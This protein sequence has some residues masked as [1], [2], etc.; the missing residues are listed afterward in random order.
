MSTPTQRYWIA[1]NG[2]SCAMSAMAMRDPVVTPTPEQMWGFPT[3]EEAQKAQQICLT[4]PMADVIAFLEGLRQDIKSGRILYRSP[5]NPG[6]Q[7]RGETVWLD[8]Q[9]AAA[10]EAA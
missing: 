9:E 10:C 4:A 5:E 8:A 6:P 2:S 1:V 3:L 7:T